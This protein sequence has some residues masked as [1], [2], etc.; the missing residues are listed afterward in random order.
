MIDDSEI[1]E[2]DDNIVLEKDKITLQKY[3]ND[4]KSLSDI[5]KLIK[6]LDGNWTVDIVSDNN[7]NSQ[8]SWITKNEKQICGTFKELKEKSVFS[9]V[10]SNLTYDNLCDYLESSSKSMYKYDNNDWNVYE[11]YKLYGLK[12]PNINEWSSF[13]I[14]ELHKLYTTYD[15]FFKLGK[16]EDFINFCFTNSNSKYLPKY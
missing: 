7:C 10:L 2:K 11:E 14:I 3:N 12:N 5:N 9:D 6:E 8:E 16:I 13:H 4:K 15:T 1:F